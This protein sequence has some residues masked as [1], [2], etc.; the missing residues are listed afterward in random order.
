MVALNNSTGS[1]PTP[2]IVH[3]TEP[4]IEKLKETLQRI[5]VLGN[6]CFRIEASSESAEMVLDTP[7]E[8]DVTLSEER[9]TLLA[10]DAQSVRSFADRVLH[11]DT[12]EREFYWLRLVDVDP[13]G[14]TC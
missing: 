13:R 7:Q 14:M 12:S 1:S 4:A 3:V 8:S 9:C 6:K 10:M 11:Y 5:N 2:S